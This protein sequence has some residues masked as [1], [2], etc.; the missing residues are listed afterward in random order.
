MSA[1]ATVTDITTVTKK[2]KVKPDNI[3]I[4]I[5]LPEDLHEKLM[6]D[7]LLSK[8]PIG[9]MA[10]EWID[11]NTSPADVTV[12][13]ATMMKTT[14]VREKPEPGVV[15]KGV[16]IPVSKRH[17]G[18]IRMEALRQ[19]TTIRA[20]LKAWIIENVKEWIFE[21]VEEHQDWQERQAA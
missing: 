6:L 10:E 4:S 5:T 1:I 9:S 15:M 2:A 14:T 16:S 7:S 20:L 17:Y 19:N 12:G 8:T 21:P 11:Q 3:S 18:M 13:L